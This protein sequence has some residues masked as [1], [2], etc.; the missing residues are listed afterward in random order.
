MKVRLIGGSGKPISGE[1]ELLFKCSRCG[2][3][4]PDMAG[5]CDACRALDLVAKARRAEIF[6]G[7]KHEGWDP[8]DE[9]LPMANRLYCP[10]CGG[11]F[12]KLDEE[13][14]EAV[15]QAKPLSFSVTLPVKKVIFGG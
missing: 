14:R 7:C 9:S 8:D 6:P 12:D 10:K 2:D 3:S 5:V 15:R 11:A 1:V 13:Q 4:T